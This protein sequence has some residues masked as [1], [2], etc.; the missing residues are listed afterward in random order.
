[1]RRD[2]ILYIPTFDVVTQL[3]YQL[4]FG[5]VL[6]ASLDTAY[7]TCERVKGDT[8]RSALDEVNEESLP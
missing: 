7:L 1:M 4:I 8:Q 3:H 5:A 6:Y 2:T